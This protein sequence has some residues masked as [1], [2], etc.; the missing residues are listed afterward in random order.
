LKV[1]ILLTSE[2]QSHHLTDPERFFLLRSTGIDYS[3]HDLTLFKDCPSN[4]K[5]HSNPQAMLQLRGKSQ[6]AHFFQQHKF[7]HPK[8]YHLGQNISEDGPFIVKPERSLGGLGQ[9]LIET[10]RSL[11]SLVSALKLWKDERFVI[12]QFKQKTCEWRFFFCTDQPLKPA[13][14]LKRG[15]HWQG[16]RGHQ[17]EQLVALEQVPKDLKSQAQ[18]A[19]ECSGLSYA[20]IDILETPQGEWLFLEVN[21]VPGFQSFQERGQNMAARIVN[22]FY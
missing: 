22:I 5:V 20:G 2:I 10:P 19:F 15:E 6:Q 14:L 9:V 17:K 3:D 12:Q 13:V 1:E 21:A 7:L 16:N 4:I 18:R 11:E 8:T